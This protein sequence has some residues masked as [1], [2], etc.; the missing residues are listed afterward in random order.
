[1]LQL[2]QVNGST[3]RESFACTHPFN[4]ELKAGQPTDSK[5][6]FSDRRH[7]MAENRTHLLDLVVR[8]LPTD[9]SQSS[10]S[11][12][13]KIESSELQC[14]KSAFSN[15]HSFKKVSIFTTAWSLPVNFN[16]FACF[17]DSD[18]CRRQRSTEEKSAI[19]SPW[20]RNHWTRTTT[21]AKH[22]WYRNNKR[23]SESISWRSREHANVQRMHWA[24]YDPGVMHVLCTVFAATFVCLYMQ[25][26]PQRRRPLR[27]ETTL[28]LASNAQKHSAVL[29]PILVQCF[30]PYHHAHRQDLAAG[31]PKTRKG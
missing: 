28:P 21:E 1:M 23:K 31:V 19:C 7:N 18:A 11:F 4:A 5:Y 29:L 6:R 22:Y 13:E 3:V 20:R 2:W 14:L 9:S 15:I 16:L 10:W 8:A 12:F 30:N 27:H 25:V 26:S 24:T 17:Q